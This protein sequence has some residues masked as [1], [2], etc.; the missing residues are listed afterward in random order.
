MAKDN[1]GYRIA[2][3]EGFDGAENVDAVFPDGFV[4]HLDLSE[5]VYLTPKD[6]ILSLEVGEHIPAQYEQNFIE[7]LHRHNKKGIVLSWS[8]EGNAINHLLSIIGILKEDQWV[9]CLQLFNE[10]S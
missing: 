9:E 4:K 2:S 3:Y 1:D 10:G 6:W 7:N 5:P 8:V